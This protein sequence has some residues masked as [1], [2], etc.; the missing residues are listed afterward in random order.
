[1]K[2]YIL[3][4]AA[5]ADLRAVIRYTTKQ[6][7]DTQVRRYVA[8]LERGIVSL[9]EGHSPFRDMSTLYPELRMA[10][11]DHHFVFCLPR[12][13]APTLVVAILHERMDLL[14]RLAGRL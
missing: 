7:G 8:A 14:T 5:E 6:W 1:M 2:S 9:V 4:E 10:R 13:S 11:V 3:T 12:E